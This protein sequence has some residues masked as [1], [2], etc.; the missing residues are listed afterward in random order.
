MFWHVCCSRRNWTREDLRRHRHH[1]LL[2][3]ALQRLQR[4]RGLLLLV[5]LRTLQSGRP[6]MT[7]FSCVKRTKQFN[8]GHNYWSRKTD[9]VIFHENWDTVKCALCVVAYSIKYFCATY[10][11]KNKKNLQ[12]ALTNRLVKF[13]GT[14]QKVQSHFYCRLNEEYYTNLVNERIALL[15]TVNNLFYYFSIKRKWKRSSDRSGSR[16]CFYLQTVTTPVHYF[17]T[18]KAIVINFG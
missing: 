3:N 2:G 18:N 1:Q 4:T 16:V 13:M 11:V 10:L 15:H 17:H 5:Q 14:M 12:A 6:N 7:R 9:R 8:A